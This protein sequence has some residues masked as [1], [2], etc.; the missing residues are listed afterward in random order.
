M[1]KIL[2]TAALLVNGIASF[3]NN[4]HYTR[5]GKGIHKS[6]FIGKWESNKSNDNA[7]FNIDIKQIKDKLTGTYCATAQ[8]GNKVDCAEGSDISFEVPVPLKNSFTC[9]FTSGYNGSKGLARLSI[10][11]KYLV[12]TIIKAPKGEYYCPATAKLV[13]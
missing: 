3:N 7:T 4:K 11:G 10:A 6:P 9:T 1:Y 13:K 5:L 12:W 8:K 2:I